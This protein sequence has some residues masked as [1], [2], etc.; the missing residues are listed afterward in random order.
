MGEMMNAESRGA[1]LPVRVGM[2]GSE[3]RLNRAVKRVTRARGDGRWIVSD[4]V[5]DDPVF[6]VHVEWVFKEGFCVS[7]VTL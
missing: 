2:D 3:M 1:V 4:I 5:A 6:P 7:G